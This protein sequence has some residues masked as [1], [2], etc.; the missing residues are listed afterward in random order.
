MSPKSRT[1]DQGTMHG[2]PEARDMSMPPQGAF[3]PGNIEPISVVLVGQD[4]ELCELR[5]PIVPTVQQLLHTMPT[6]QN[7]K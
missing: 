4:R 2:C 7:T 1:D 3:L 5:H 6:S